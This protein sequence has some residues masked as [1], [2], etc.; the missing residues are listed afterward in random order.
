[1]PVL[2]ASAAVKL[3]L[4]EPHSDLAKAY[5]DDPARTIIAPDFLLAETA[6][7]MRNAV[8][9]GRISRPDAL[10]AV[11]NLQKRVNRLVPIGPFVRLALEMALE[12]RHPVSD[13]VYLAQAVEEK[14]ILVTAD[15][16]FLEKTENS[17][18]RAFAVS[19]Q[20]A[21]GAP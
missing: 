16:E 9:D 13:C 3:Y 12:L 18:W 7:A 15:L 2:D 20:N 1:M 19:L 17:R 5:V 8:R 6:A 4:D 14:D 10:F 11:E 21:A